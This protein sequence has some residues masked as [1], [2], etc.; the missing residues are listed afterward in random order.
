[1]KIKGIT[2]QGYKGTLRSLESYK[3][4]LVKGKVLESKTMLDYGAEIAAYLTKKG[5]LRKNLSKKKYEQFNKL[6]KDF[7]ESPYSSV[8]K[9]KEITQKADET[10]T[11]THAGATM[12]EAQSVREIFVMANDNKVKLGSELVEALADDAENNYKISSNDY[13]KI[14][15]EYLNRKATYTPEE[16]QDY[17]EYDDTVR[18]M[19]KLMGVFVG[20]GNDKEFKDVF[21]SLIDSERSVADIEKINTVYMSIKNN[22]IL[23]KQLETMLKENRSTQDI[24]KHFQKQKGVELKKGHLI[25][26]APLY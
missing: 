26:N 5:E 19:Q 23:K 11:K 18:E 9:L 6:V 25:F 1:M 10:Y 13:K 21:F 3:K 14:L 15:D 22:S 8:K 7:K 4:Q 20:M 24:I 17:L 2:I 12:A 16:A